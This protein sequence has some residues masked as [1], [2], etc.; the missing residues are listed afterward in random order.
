MFVDFLFGF[1]AM[2]VACAMFSVAMIGAWYLADHLAWQF[3]QGSLSREAQREL[4]KARVR[5]RR[6]DY[7]SLS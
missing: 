6:A 1:A 7:E 3:R 4:S 5:A 2:V